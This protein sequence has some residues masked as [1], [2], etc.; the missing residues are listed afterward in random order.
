[1]LF[2]GKGKG[3]EHLYRTLLYY[4]RCGVVVVPAGLAEGWHLW[5]TVCID[6]DAVFAVC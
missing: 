3:R 6:L 1:M 2:K 5:A 4:F